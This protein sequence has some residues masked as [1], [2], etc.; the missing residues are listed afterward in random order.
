MI[1]ATEGT[2][3]DRLPP[4][5]EIRRG[6]PLEMPHV[7]VLIDDRENRLM[8][9]LD[10]RRSSLECLYDFSL[11]QGG[12]HLTGYRVDD[13]RLLLEVAEQLSALREQGDGFL[14]AMG[15]ATTPLLRP[16]PAGRS[17]SPP[18]PPLNGSGIPRAGRWPSWSACT[19]RRWPSNRFT[20]CSTGWTR[21]PYSGKSALTPPCPPTHRFC[22]RCST[23]GW[24]SILKRASITSMA[25]EECPPRRPGGLRPAGSRF[26]AL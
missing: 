5:V 12:G 11:M 16:K 26:P 8:D 19:I 17:S 20:G 23:A 24:R 18:S 3:V 10:A 25:R 1:R 9:T 4:R 6:A 15:T 14:Y 2:V 21:R 7:M 13:P 22:S